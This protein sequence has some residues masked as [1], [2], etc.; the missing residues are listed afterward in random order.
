MPKKRT[1]APSAVQLPSGKWR[2]QVMVSGQRVSVVE[3][4][5]KVA[6]AKAME[7]KAGL[8]QKQK[9][10]ES[11]TVGQA[12]DRY[13]ESKDSVLSP[14]T[15][16]GYK[17]IRAN[18]LQELMDV[19][20]CFLTQESVQRAVNKMAKEHSPKSVRNAHGLLSAAMGVYRPD[21]VLRTT[22]PQ[23]V[24]YEVAIPSGDDVE[25]IMRACKGDRS[26]LP[27]LMAMWLGMRMSEILGARW[28]DLNGNVL[29]IQN[30]LIDEG[31]KTTKTYSGN[32][33]IIV[34][35][36]ILSLMK[37][38]PHKSDK[39]VQTNR[40]ALYYW[41][42]DVCKKAGVQHYRFHDLRHINASVM[43]ALG[44]PD[45]YAQERMGHATNSMLKTVYQH[46]MK[47]EQIDVAQKINAYFESK[48]HT[49]L[50]TESDSA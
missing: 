28:T 35:D 19:K 41:F 20:L 48:L 9:S 30:A 25:A 50:H 46:T 42:Q 2:C 31:E 23:K 1:S 38:A 15:I 26:E 16:A 24:R 29:H 12:I 47:Q 37:Q 13:I 40:R 10:V 3:D 27:I 33:Y 14:S 18:A 11:I 49:D 17:R 22:L 44:I 6:Q 8:K 21:M 4:D 43:L 32:R 34:P 7:I 36:Y 5:P 39:I 45:K